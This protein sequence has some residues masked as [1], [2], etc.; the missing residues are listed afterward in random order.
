MLGSKYLTSCRKTIVND[1]MH[2]GQTMMS[3]TLVKL[4]CHGTKEFY[5]CSTRVAGTVTLKH[6]FVCWIKNSFRF[7]LSIR[8]AGRMACWKVKG[9]TLDNQNLPNH[10]QTDDN[11]RPPLKTQR[12]LV[13]IFRYFENQ[14]QRLLAFF[15]IQ[16][17]LFFTLKF[18]SK[19][20]FALKIHLQSS[21]FSPAAG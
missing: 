8:G 14:I 2:F 17:L 19:T 4:W 18:G 15:K 9:E 11:R 3:C 6:R 7:L 12:Q 16:R 5:M 13:W 21:K 10:Y 1:V 20:H